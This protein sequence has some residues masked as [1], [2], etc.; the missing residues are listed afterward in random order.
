MS[1]SKLSFIPHK[2]N[3]VEECLLNGYS[4][5]I[6]WIYLYDKN[7]FKRRNIIKNVI[8]SIVALPIIL[9]IVWD[10]QSNIQDSGF[11]ANLAQE[12][13]TLGVPPG[14]TEKSRDYTAG[15][16]T[17]LPTWIIHYNCQTTGGPIYSAIT[18]R[19]DA[20][21]FIAD[22]DSS[23]FPSSLQSY[24]LAYH[25]DSFNIKYDI[26]VPESEEAQQRHNLSLLQH[27]I[28]QEVTLTIYKSHD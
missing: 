2:K 17:T 26:Y 13:S 25:R 6:Y 22:L 16:I 5:A 23:S 18:E 27:S 15:G 3:V 19:L 20:E 9:F 7:M 24:E 4:V 8:L 10:I 21:H 12:V 14:C 28:V 11:K 1:A